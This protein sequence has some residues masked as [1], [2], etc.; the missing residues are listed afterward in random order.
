MS[1]LEQSECGLKGRRVESQI[2][3]NVGGSDLYRVAILHWSLPTDRSYPTKQVSEWTFGGRGRDRPLGEV[4]ARRRDW[5]WRG[6]NLNDDE[7][8]RSAGVSEWLDGPKTSPA[9][10]LVS[11]PSAMD[12]RLTMLRKFIPSCKGTAGIRLSG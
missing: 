2:R 4:K 7:E 3:G 11:P 10:N 9:S 8:M 5:L 6:C 1:R 12:H